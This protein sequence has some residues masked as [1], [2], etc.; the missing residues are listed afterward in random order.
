[1]APFFITFEGVD[2]CGKTTI[3]RR[4]TTQLKKTGNKISLTVEPT[5]TWLGDAVRQSYRVKTSPYTEAFLFIADRATHTDWIR[6][7][8]AKGRHVFSDRYSDSTVAYQAA[9]LHQKL[10]GQMTEYREWLLSVNNKIIIQPDLTI[11]FDVNPGESLKRLTRRS[12]RSKFERLKYLTLVRENYL[13]IAK[14]EARITVID[15]GRP[16]KDVYFEAL[17]TVTKTL[18]RKH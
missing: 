9:L 11:L 12:E 5:K 10:G 18:S 6:N 3:C 13:A 4:M 7:T 14:K 17:N 8:M 16:F 2:G 1:M 15:A